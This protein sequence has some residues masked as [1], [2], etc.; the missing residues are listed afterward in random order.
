[1]SFFIEKNWWFLFGISFLKIM[2]C[3]FCSER[4]HTRKNC[5]N[6]HLLIKSQ[7]LNKER[8]DKEK[9]TVSLDTNKTDNCEKEN[10]SIKSNDREKSWYIYNT[11]NSVT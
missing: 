5:T 10:T 3:T 4:G 1:M 9:Q 8:L 7:Q 11:R 2:M 6:L